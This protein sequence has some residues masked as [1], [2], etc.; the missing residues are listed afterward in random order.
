VHPTVLTLGDF[1]E[2]QHAEIAKWGKVIHDS[3]V[4]EII[5]R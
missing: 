4:T 5:S 1:A 3:G 2:F